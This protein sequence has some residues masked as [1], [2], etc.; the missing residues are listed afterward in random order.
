MVTE[1]LDVEFERA[2]VML[3]NEDVLTSLSV[4]MLEQTRIHF[5]NVPLDSWQVLSSP[6]AQH[7][8]KL[9]KTSRVKA[10]EKQTYVVYTTQ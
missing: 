10:A 1:V 9:L 7:L 6:P 2:E 8:V 4:L 3:R 5:Q